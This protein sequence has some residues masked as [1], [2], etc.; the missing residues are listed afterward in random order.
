M[1]ILHRIA[2]LM[3]IVAIFVAHVAIG[4]EVEAETETEVSIG[5]EGGRERG[6]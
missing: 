4:M 2:L 1:A 5:R 3:A 6:R